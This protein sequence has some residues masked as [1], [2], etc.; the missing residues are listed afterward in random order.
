MGDG[1]YVQCPHC[2]MGW[3]TRLLCVDCLLRDDPA[4]E[5]CHGTGDAGLSAAH[6]CPE[7]YSRETARALADFHSATQIPVSPRMKAR[8]RLGLVDG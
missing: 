1:E 4:C 7:P 3:W 5:T 8:I 2:G 6:H